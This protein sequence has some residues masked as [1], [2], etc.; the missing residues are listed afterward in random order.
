M[1]RFTKLFGAVLLLCACAAEPLNAQP[2]YFP[3]L[4][5]FCVGSGLNSA[6][7]I[8]FLV[9][10]AFRGGPAPQPV[11]AVGDLNCRGGVGAADIVYL[12]NY[13]YR[14]GPPPCD[15]CGP[16][17]EDTSGFTEAEIM[18]MWYSD[19][20]VGPPLLRARMQNDLRRIRTQFGPAHAGITGA[21]FVAPWDPSHIRLAVDS[22][23]HDAMVEG[24][25]HDW[26]SLNNLY[27]LSEFSFGGYGFS[28]WALD[29]RFQG[30]QNPKH[31]A[32]A[33]SQLPGVNRITYGGY[34]GSWPSVYPLQRG[35]TI[36][37]LFEYAWG[38]C[39][40]GCIDHIYWYSAATDDKV[41]FIGEWDARL[42]GT[43]PAWWPEA[44]ENLNRYW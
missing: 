43:P 15:Y 39:P 29:L 8:I 10:Y 5:G 4:S 33:Y 26:D 6:E 16:R 32:A 2:W 23:T 3:G 7:D 17:W 31:L 25:Y 20:I 12:V 21:S 14:S 30:L 13:V 38:D 36:T 34:A 22:A 42:P 40:S 19:S 9:D 41:W 37:Y 24:N 28:G 18:A 27:S 44:Y 35:E 1:S 11:L